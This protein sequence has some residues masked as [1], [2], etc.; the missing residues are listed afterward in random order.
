MTRLE[1]EKKKYFDFE[2]SDWF[3]VFLQLNVRVSSH[4]WFRYKFVGK[5]KQKSSNIH[6]NEMIMRFGFCFEKSSAIVQRNGVNSNNFSSNVIPLNDNICFIR[7]DEL[8]CII[9]YNYRFN[10]QSNP[11]PSNNN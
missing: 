11:F 8:Y 6:L 4:F 7:S 1:F 10:Q 3:A 9:N 5:C 2:L